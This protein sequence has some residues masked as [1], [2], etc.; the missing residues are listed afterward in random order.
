MIICCTFSQI[1]SI[2]IW[3]SKG[4]AGPHLRKHCLIILR[5]PCMENSLPSVAST[6]Y[7]QGL[8]HESPAS[9][10]WTTQNSFWG[11][12]VTWRYRPRFSGDVAHQFPHPGLTRVVT[13][14][15]PHVP[16]ISYGFTMCVVWTSHS[17]ARSQ[18]HPITLLTQPRL[19]F[20]PVP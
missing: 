9:A 16:L 14:S 11:L 15:P 20:L 2:P 7:W 12:P 4:M 8:P 19:P 13:F 18:Y 3:D 10:L 17:S 6:S 1:N 5:G